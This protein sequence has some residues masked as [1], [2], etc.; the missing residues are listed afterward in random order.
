MEWPL[1]TLNTLLFQQPV[2]NFRCV[3]SSTQL[4]HTFTIGG[5]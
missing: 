1:A 4:L 2:P 5:N 3:W